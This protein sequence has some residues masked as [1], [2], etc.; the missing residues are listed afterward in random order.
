[1]MKYRCQTCGKQ[2]AEDQ[3]LRAAN[4]FGGLWRVLGC[5][6][7]MDI[8]TFE[9]LCQTKGCENHTDG[10]IWANGEYRHLCRKHLKEAREDV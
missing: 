7:C 9:P 6:N 5:P 8:N 10:G 4:P 2:Y 1:M 3:F